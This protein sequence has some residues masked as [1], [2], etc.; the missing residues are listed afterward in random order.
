MS[1][2]LVVMMRGINVGGAKKVPMAE[3]RTAL[4]DSGCAGVSTILAT[5]NVILDGDDTAAAADHVERLVEERFDVASR[6]L[7]RTAE[8]IDQVVAA[9]PFADIADNGS[10]YLAVFLSGPAPEALDDPE[11]PI[12]LDTETMAVGDRLIYQWCPDG[13]LAAE[14]IGDTVMKHTDLFVT[15]RNWNTV[16]KIQARLGSS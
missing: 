1:G 4:T 2:R 5:G 13:I 16:L 14:P 3:L 7:A 11:G 12:G 8:E 15:A 6:C 10:K 9:D